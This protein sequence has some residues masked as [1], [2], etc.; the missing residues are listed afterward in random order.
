MSRF[1]NGRA[2]YYELGGVKRKLHWKIWC[3][4]VQ[5][6]LARK[7]KGSSLSETT[8]ASSSSSSALYLLSS[9]IEVEDNCDTRC[10]KPI[11]RCE[12]VAR[13]LTCVS[14]I[15]DTIRLTTSIR[16][17]NFLTNSES[18]LF[19]RAGKLADTTCSIAYL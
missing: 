1:I 17:R 14:L 2:N 13:E 12:L 5:R 15:D 10:T 19:P 6:L 4:Q 18:I 9:E 3:E 7:L 11:F 8:A 16:V